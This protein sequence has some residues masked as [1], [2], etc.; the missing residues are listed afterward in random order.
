MLAGLGFFLAYGLVLVALRNG[1]RRT[2][3][4][5]SGETSGV[6]AVLLL[7]A[8]GQEPLQ[9]RSLAGACLVAAGWRS[10][11][12][13]L[14]CDPVAGPGAVTPPG[15]GLGWP[16][17]T[18]GPSGPAPAGHEGLRPRRPTSARPSRWCCSRP[19]SPSPTT[20]TRARCWSPLAVL[21]GQLS[22]GW[23][24]DLVDEARRAVGRADK[25]LA[26]GR[27]PAVPSWSVASWPVAVVV[28]S[29]ACGWWA[30]PC[31]S[32]CVASAWA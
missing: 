9:A 3:R 12:R 30:A 6:I 14:V 32:A 4:R 22:V 26:T 2:G 5:G 31:I 1:A 16:R 7:A 15:T 25:P 28:L 10:W 29:F 17:L 24:N 20:P 8:T 19:C 21:A 23:C 18:R 27:F 13:D 11:S